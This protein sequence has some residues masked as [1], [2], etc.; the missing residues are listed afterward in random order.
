MEFQTAARHLI[1]VGCVVA[2]AW[3]RELVIAQAMCS[4]FAACV[5]GKEHPISVAFAMGLGSLQ[6][7]A[8]VPGTSMMRAAFATATA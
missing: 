7:N 8:T 5:E 3:P 1:L 6:A 4:T 2:L